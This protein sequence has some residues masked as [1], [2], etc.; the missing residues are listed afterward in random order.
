MAPTKV[1]QLYDDGTNSQQMMPAAGAREQRRRVD[2]YEVRGSRHIFTTAYIC[3][4]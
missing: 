3:F 4:C 1:P 2:G